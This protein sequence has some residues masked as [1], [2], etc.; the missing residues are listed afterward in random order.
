MGRKRDRFWDYAEELKGRFKC[1]Y[2]KREFPGGASRIKSHLAGVK[3]RDI[4]ICDVVPEHVQKEAYEATQATNKKLENASTSSKYMESTIASTSISTTIQKEKF[5]TQSEEE[6]MAEIVLNNVVDRLVTKAFSL[7]IKDND[8]KWGFEEELK[9]IS[10]TLFKIK[11]VL[12]QKRQVSDKPVRI[13]LMELRNVAYEVDNVLDEFNNEII[14]QK[15]LLQNQMI[16]QVRSFSFCNHN[17]IKTIKQSLDKLVNG[18]AGFGLRTELLKS[19]IKIRLGKN[20][21]SFLNESEV[22]GRECEVVEI[23][24]K[25]ISS[26]NQQVI[27]VL[28]IIG[29]AGH[30][31][32][33]LAKVLYNHEEIKKHF[34]V[35]GWVHVSENLEVE[36][37]SRKICESLKIDSTNLER[38]KYFLVLDDIWIKDHD[39]WDI[40]R[41]R[42]VGINSNTRITIIVTTR[43]NKVAQIMGTLPPHSLEK[44]SKAD[45]WSILKKRV[46]ADEGKSLTFDLEASGMEIAKRCR[47]IPL[48]ARVLG[49]AMCFTCD[50]NEWLAIKNDKIWD[51]LD[52]NSDIFP[53]LKL[54]FDNLPIPSLKQC[55]TYCALFPKDYDIK[56]DEVIQYWMAEGFLEPAKEGNTTMENIGNMYFNI[57][58]ATSFFQN[59]RND[60]YGNIISCKMHGL[61]RDFA[62]SISNFETLIL[63]RDSMDD[64]SNVQRLFVPYDGRTTLGTSFNGDGFIKLRTLIVENFD[65]DDMLSNFKCLRVLKLSVDCKMGLS[66]SIEQLMHLR[67]LHIS[68]EIEELPQSITKLYNLQTLRIE[69]CPRLKKLPEDLSNL[70]NLRHINIRVDAIPTPKN[71]GRL[72]NL[73]TLSLFAVGP[74]EGFRIKELGPLMN[75]RG[76]IKIRNLEHVEGEEEAKSAK[77]KRKGNIQLGII[78]A[79]SSG[80]G[81]F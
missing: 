46:F 73:Q 39:K 6:Y 10:D 24:N 66:D 15:V 31:K 22:F 9:N 53:A 81:H 18:V 1:N 63:E 11:V 16:D 47:G 26:S 34:D 2:C 13:W 21:D 20:E 75:L 68:F 41:S 42:L 8:F 61:V 54:W 19:I 71:M 30:G 37:I 43:S 50:K 59:V 60:D 45:C 38:K 32:T 80:R 64:T 62:L 12:H 23:V 74:D 35:L 4:V 58:L 29:M 33:T 49:E 79:S 48:V 76:E 28:P 36:E 52:D 56:K 70:F 69:E 77:F 14:Q 57:L 72:T 17:K 78:L 25:L 7:A 65:F 55:F 44:L 67:L 5:V 3:G 40:L 27:S 51:L